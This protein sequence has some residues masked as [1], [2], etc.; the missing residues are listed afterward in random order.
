MRS[1]SGDWKTVN[2]N[3]GSEVSRVLQ[4]QCVLCKE[5]NDEKVFVHCAAGVKVRGDQVGTAASA[6][7]R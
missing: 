3:E 7:G 2:M 6:S 4:T 1:N 5:T